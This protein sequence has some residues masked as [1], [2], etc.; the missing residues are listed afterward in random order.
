MLQNVLSHLVNLLVLMDLW[1]LALLYVLL[2]LVNL[3]VLCYL[4]HLLG[5]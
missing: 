4:G 2:H 5:L 1:L 3:L